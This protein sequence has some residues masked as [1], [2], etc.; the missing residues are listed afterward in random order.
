MFKKRYIKAKAYCF[1]R[2]AD[3]YR[4]L[5]QGI[6]Y[7]WFARRQNACVSMGKRNGGVPPYKRRVADS[8]GLFD[9]QFSMRFCG[10]RSA[11]RRAEYRRDSLKCVNLRNFPR[12]TSFSAP[13]FR[14]LIDFKCCD[15]FPVFE[16]KIWILL[17]CVEFHENF[18]HIRL[19]SISYVEPKNPTF[20]PNL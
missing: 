17:T 10:K 14:Y 12:K 15:I 7:K 11:W 19:I 6:S 5:L 8:R 4:Y 9:A 3:S 18:I 16:S 20:F 2:K 13:V 1:I